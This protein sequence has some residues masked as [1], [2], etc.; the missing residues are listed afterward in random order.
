L[1]DE[2]RSFLLEY[3]RF[4]QLEE[5]LLQAGMKEQDYVEV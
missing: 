5:T 4:R 2:G 3:D 1:T